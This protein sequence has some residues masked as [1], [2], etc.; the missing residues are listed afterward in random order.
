[1]LANKIGYNISQIV[2]PSNV[3]IQPYL[4]LL[5]LLNCRTRYSA[6]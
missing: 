6:G 3:G 4:K 1:M 5:R 2:I